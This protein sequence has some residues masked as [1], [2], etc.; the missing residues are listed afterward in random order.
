MR[1]LERREGEAPGWG[2]IAESALPR[3]GAFGQ[4]GSRGEV[5]AGAA[6]GVVRGLEG[7]VALVT[8]GS[9]GLGGAFVLRLA[10]EGVHVAVGG[11]D[12]E[13]TAAVVAAATDRAQAAGHAIEA[14]AALGD[15]GVVAECERIVQGTVERHG[16]LDVL[17]CSAGV[18]LEKPMVDTTEADWDD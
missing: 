6:G 1:V 2:R 12:P 5:A 11:R 3:K 18:F 4:D 13:R 15:V 16:R 9:S 7:K 8:G 10:E 17:V 14:S